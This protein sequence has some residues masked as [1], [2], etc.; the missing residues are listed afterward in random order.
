VAS[1][2]AKLGS[3]QSATPNRPV[4]LISSIENVGKHPA[5]CPS[6][7][8][9]RRD[10]AADLKLRSLP[11]YSHG[12]TT[13]TRFATKPAS[14]S[15]AIIQHLLFQLTHKVA[16]LNRKSERFSFI[17]LVSIKVLWF[18]RYP[19]T[20]RLRLLSNLLSLWWI[21]VQWHDC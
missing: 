19:P 6:V 16:Y 3:I 21:K 18:A 17:Y 12:R 9:S 20:S 14:K 15:V 7:F 2:C 10:K 5:S 8:N 13:R 4:Q 1:A 11:Y